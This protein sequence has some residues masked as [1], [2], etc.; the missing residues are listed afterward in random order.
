LQARRKKKE[1]KEIGRSFARL[2]GRKGK[3]RGRGGRVSKERGTPI[4]FDPE[5]GDES[6]LRK[7]QKGGGSGPPERGEEIVHFLL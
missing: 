4:L 3:D 7:R 2:E 5:K 6:A 1:G